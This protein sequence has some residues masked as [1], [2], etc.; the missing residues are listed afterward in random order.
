MIQHSYIKQQKISK[1][2]GNKQS[3]HPY[4]SF[5]TTKRSKKQ[6][7]NISYRKLYFMGIHILVRV[8]FI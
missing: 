5:A 2:K 1:V 8:F 3:H 6:Q 7:T 4:T